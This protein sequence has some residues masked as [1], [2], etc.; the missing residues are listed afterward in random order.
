MNLILF[1]CSTINDKFMFDQKFPWNYVN[2]DPKG[3]NLESDISTLRKLSNKNKIL[4]IIGNT[5]PYYIY[6]QSFSVY[7]NL[8]KKLLWKK[9]DARWQKYKQNLEIWLKQNHV[10]YFQILSWREF[11]LNIKQQ[12]GI[13][14]ES[15][16]NNL[17]PKI[18][19]YFSQKDF[20][21]EF[22]KLK[23]AFG[24]DQYFKNLK[25]PSDK[26]LK[27]WIKR[28]F[29]EYTLQGLFLYL[30]FP[31]YTL[32]QNEKPTLLRNKMYQ[33]LIKAFFNKNLPVITPFGI[34]NTSYQ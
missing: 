13:D 19:T 3:N 16:F 34:D 5:D 8:D 20:D 14:F 17:L 23:L 9:F 32:A 1:T 29:T 2:L 18:G 22:R 15:V 11:E 28:K 30:F 12:I 21:L 4:I 7:P 25:Q 27:I 10:F 6:S 24:P 26:I 31:E 33:P